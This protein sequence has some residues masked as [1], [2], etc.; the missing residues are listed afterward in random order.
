[1]VYVDNV[2]TTRWAF[3]RNPTSAKIAW[4]LSAS[5]QS[6]AI[7]LII[8]PRSKL[9]TLKIHSAHD[10]GIRMSHNIA[11]TQ[12]RFFVFLHSDIFSVITAHS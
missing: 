8:I 11:M 1:M 6:D 12:F 7:L 4:N 3:S 9:A 2:Y 5:S 10:L